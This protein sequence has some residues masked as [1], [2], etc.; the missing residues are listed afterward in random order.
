MFDLFRSRDKAVRILLG[1]LLLMVAISMLAYL[2]PNYG[3]S[4]SSADMVLAEV[5]NDVITITEAQKVVQ[6]AMRNRQLPPEVLPNYVPQMVEQMIIE[7]AMAYE[8]GRLG[9]Q[10]SDADVADAIRQ[11]VPSLYQDGKFVGREA[12]ANMLAA[13]NM[14]IEQFENDLRRQVLITRLRDVAIEGQVVNPLEIEQVFR[15][16][17]EKIKIEYVK[18]TADKYKGESQPSA[19]DM[20]AYYKANIARYQVPEKLNLTILVADQARLEQSVNPTDAE[21]QRLYSQNQDAYRTKERIRVRHI[22]VMTQGKPPAD[23][24][25]LKAKAEDLL[26]QVRAKADFAKL[27]K[28]NSEDPGSKDKG[29]EYWVQHDGQ[30]AKEFE[31]AAFRLKPGQSDLIKTSYGYH[32]FE[33]ME[34][35]DAGLRSFAEVKSDLSAEAKKQKVNDLMQAASDKAQAALAK[36]PA[37]PEK[38]AADFNLQIVRAAFSP[39]VPIPELGPSPD[40]DQS[41]SGLKKG[42][43]SPPVAVTNKIAFAVVTDVIPA[44]PSTFEEVQTQ[45]RDTIVQQ[46]SSLAAQTHAK[47]LVEKANAAGGDLAKAAKSMGLEVKTSNE[48]DRA[49][50][51]EGLGGASYVAEGFTKPDGTVFGPVSPPDGATVVCRVVAHVQPDL[52]KLPEQRA[53]IRDD[54]KG[55]RARDRNTLFESGVKDALTRQGKVKVHQDVFSRLLAGYISGRG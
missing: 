2:I 53:I 17:N 18:L 48:V 6:G 24:P 36:D 5:G 32:V 19:P 26:K 42:Q 10:V 8:A 1:A 31:D 47:E 55:Q 7:R 3:S 29:G 34:H 28:E 45:I 22:L 43:V 12:Y 25:K 46:R 21:L 35:Q 38:V 54:I 52:S 13:Q 33:V 23:E 41:V 16:K 51:I 14:T 9:F 37:N 27:A 40:F 30:M 15:K 39:G 11:M 20:Q 50:N 4:S 44:R 49:G